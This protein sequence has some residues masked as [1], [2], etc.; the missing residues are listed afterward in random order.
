MKE[1]EKEKETEEEEEEE[2][3]ERKVRITH[4]TRREEQYSV[5]VRAIRNVLYIG[6]STSL[7]ALA[8]KG[9]QGRCRSG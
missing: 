2:K 8:R 5:C 4:R 1:K 3:G 6:Q 7:C 9:A